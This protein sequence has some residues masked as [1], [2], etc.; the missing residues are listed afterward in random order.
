VAEV[1]PGRSVPERVLRLSEGSVR[2]QERKIATL[3]VSGLLAAIIC[4]GLL[5]SS[6][7][8]ENAGY[9]FGGA[10]AGF[11]IT[12]VLLNRFWGPDSFEDQVAKSGAEIAFEEIVKVLDLRRAPPGMNAQRVRLCD[13]RRVAKAKKERDLHLH[14][15]TTGDGIAF[16]GSATHPLTADW[17]TGQIT[18]HGPDGEQLKRQY[19][20][21]IPLADVATGEVV[22]IAIEVT[23]VDAFK[24]AEREWL[25]THID[26]P[27][28]RL[29][30]IVLMPDT[31]AATK[32]EIMIRKEGRKEPPRLPEPRVM[33]NGS[34]VYWSIDKPLPETR[35]ALSWH[36]IARQ[37]RTISDHTDGDTETA[38]D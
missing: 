3:V 7:A 2:G 18:H 22:P 20:L 19:D 27:T 25:E 1:R 13:Y 34:V 5:E 23:Y 4:F 15:A 10:F 6:G 29:I 21:N 28:H 36:W 17:R 35:Y 16:E 14:Y 12:L 31:M 24:G 32:A 8:I 26:E 33:L 9:K 11:L 37:G 30:M 38:E